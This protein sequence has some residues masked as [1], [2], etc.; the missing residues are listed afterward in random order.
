MRTWVG[1]LLVLL[2][3]AGSAQH[4]PAPPVAVFSE[5]DDGRLVR[6]PVGAKLVVRLPEQGGVPLQWMLRDDRRI[7]LIGQPQ[8]ESRAEPGI[9]GGPQVRVFRLQATAGG[10]IPLV[11][12]L[13]SPIPGH[14]RGQER[15]V[16]ITL[17]ASS[18]LYVPTPAERPGEEPQVVGE[19]EAGGIVFTRQGA[20]V[21]LQLPAN[22]STG[23]SWQVLSSRNVAFDTP[24]G[25]EFRPGFLGIGR[26]NITVIRVRTTGDRSDGFLTMGYMPPGQE[27]SRNRA[28]RVL[29]YQFNNQRR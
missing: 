17:D 19:R 28:V 7:D 1:A 13:R 18:A 3:G 22:P 23:Y 20:L 16:V 11:F 5:R 10:R 15:R 12:R 27:P 25:V 2:A 8:V 21:E 4:R 29:E 6:L 14:D 26:G 24:P 9:V